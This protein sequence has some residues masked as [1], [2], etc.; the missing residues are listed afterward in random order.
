M[1]VNIN[2]IPLIQEHVAALQSKLNSIKTTTSGLQQVSISLPSF[3]PELNK[4]FPQQDASIAQLDQALTSKIIEY[5]TGMLEVRAKFPQPKSPVM[6]VCA[7]W[8]G[9]PGGS[10]GV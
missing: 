1:E 6:P 8:P 3:N 4:N 10:I 5:R 9:I 7:V 2:P